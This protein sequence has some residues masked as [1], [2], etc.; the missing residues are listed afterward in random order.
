M[1]C[2]LKCALQNTT[3]FMEKATLQVLGL[4]KTPWLPCIQNTMHLDQRTTLPSILT[5]GWDNASCVCNFKYLHLDLT[6]WVVCATSNTHIWIWQCE[7]YV[8]LQILTFGSDNVSCMCN[9][10]YSHLDLTMWAVCATSN[11]HIWIWQCEL[12]VQLQILTF[13]SDNVSCMC[14]FKYSHLDLTMWAVC[15]TSNTHIWIWQC[16]LYMWKWHPKE[17]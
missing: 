16:E 6:M 13:G 4:L 9:F 12:Y 17:N 10:K 2:S 3:K 11:T 14:N 7:L 1:D 5:F 15:A 8:Q